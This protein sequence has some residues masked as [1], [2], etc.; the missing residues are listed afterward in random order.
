MRPQVIAEENMALDLR[1]TNL[2][3]MKMVTVEAVS[4]FNE[5]PTARDPYSPRGTYQG[6]RAGG[7][8]HPES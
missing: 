5:V 2:K 6:T 4:C 1:V 8:G 7:P 3:S